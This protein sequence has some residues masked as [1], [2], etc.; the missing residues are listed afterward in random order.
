M[1]PQKTPLYDLHV[2]LGGKIVD[3][4]G[5]LLPVQYA[6]GIL[7]EHKVVRTAAGLFDVSHMGEVSIR[8]ENAAAAVRH[9]VTN[10]VSTMT[11]GQCRY[12]LMC[13][14]NGTIVDDLLIYRFAADDYFIVVNAA[15]VE[16]DFA[17]MKAHLLP[18]ATITNLS[19]SYA[20]IALQGPKAK[21]VLAKVA[22]LSKVPVKNYHFA[23]DIDVGGVTCIVSTTGYTGEAGYEFYC[24]AANGIKLYNLLLAAGKDLGAEPAGLGARDTLR[25]EASMPLYGHELSN[26]TVAN[27]VGL[28][29]FIKTDEDFIGRDAILAHK[30]AFKR[31]GLKLVDRGI[32]R[33]HQDVYDAAGA[34]IGHTTSGGP[35]PTLGG[36]YAMARVKA[37]TPSDAPVF[38]DVRGRKLKAVFTPLPF[39]KRP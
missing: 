25:F 1:Q 36:A 17:W 32:A 39:Y 29:A 34:K 9:L 23:R 30:P 4:A 21:D 35:A 33:E 3:F 14:E 38:I 18:G 26:E 12:A 7:H 27:E 24:A 16:K 11:D 20:E 8:G 28:D 2:A 19:A 10:R 22:D 31:I 37:S 6:N 13:Y 15:N 5:F